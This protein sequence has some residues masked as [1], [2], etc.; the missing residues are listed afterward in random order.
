MALRV[1]GGRYELVAFVGRG[2]MGEVWEGRDRVIERRVAVKVLPHDRRDAWGAELFLREA[3]TAGGLN[4]A[5]VVTVFDLG[6]DPDDGALY[7]VMEFLA[8]RD[9]ET[10]LREDGAPQVPTAVDWA[11]QTAAA[12]QNAHM[13]GVVHR[14]LKPANLMLTPDDQ[15][16]ILDFGIARYMA[17]THKSSKVIGT[18]AYMPPER[19]GDHSGDAR[20]DLYSLGCVLHELLTGSTPFQATEPV[21]MMAAHLNTPPEPPGRARPGVPAALDDLVMTLLAKDPDDRPASAAEVRDRLRELSAATPAPGA[22]PRLSGAD[23]RTVTAPLTGAGPGAARA[24]VRVPGPA[25]GTSTPVGRISRRTALRLG[26]GTAA[27]VGIAATAFT[28]YDHNT[29]DDH[30]TSA[31]HD[32]P[33]DHTTTDPRLR[34]RYATDNAVM[35]SPTVAGGVVYVGSD[36]KNV[37]ALDAATG[38]R[39]W[40]HPTGGKIEGAPTVADGVVYVGSSDGSVYAL[41]AASGKRKWHHPTGEKL[42]SAPTVADG[43]VYIGGSRDVTALDAATGKRKWAVSCDS[44]LELPAVADGVVYVAGYNSVTAL[45]AATGDEKWARRASDWGYDRNVPWD[46]TPE[47]WGFTAPTVADGVVYVGSRKRVYALDTA[48]GN[49]KWAYTTGDG[50]DG[51]PTVADNVVYLGCSNKRVYALDAATGNK[52]WGF[53]TGGRVDGA[54]MVADKVVYI[55]SFDHKV[56][57]LDAATGNKKWAYATG[58]GVQSS[59]TVVDGVVYVGSQDHNVYALKTTIENSPA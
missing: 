25:A 36:D 46:D 5:G 49:K 34:W 38:K 15:I 18:L 16:K 22:G 40:H 51:A 48:T 11:A 7:L 13:A 42:E 6:Q 37:Y 21:A 50:I 35:S 8:G 56:Y 47:D 53:D 23:T 28:L 39:K 41:D 54:P 10:V 30:N 12:L 24:P 20:S 43:V 1:V 33:V 2:G 4:H 17:S 52:K 59:P 19:F 32:N 9:L 45:V 14:D 44:S 27:S 3:R 58:E 26:I 55:G 57:A 31:D 29:S